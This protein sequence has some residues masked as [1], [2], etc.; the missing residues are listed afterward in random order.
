[1]KFPTRAPAR[2]V[3]PPKCRRLILDYRLDIEPPYLEISAGE[4]EIFSTPAE[5][6][7]VFSLAIQTLLFQMNVAAASAVV[8]G[9]SDGSKK[10]SN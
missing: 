4:G 5:P 8:K 10:G 1:M 6:A 2:V 7:Y 9:G 3:R